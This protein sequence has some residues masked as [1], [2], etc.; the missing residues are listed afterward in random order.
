MIHR[1]RLFFIGV[2]FFC[3]V[4]PVY[5][6]TDFMK[7]K[8]DEP[9]EITANK[10]EAFHEKNLVVFSGNARVIQGN[11]TLKSDRIYLYYK[12]EPGKKQKT[13]MLAAEGGTELDKVEAK[14]N[15]LLIQGDR[16]A[17]GDEALYLR[18]SNR[19]I[20]NGNATLREGKNVIRGDRVIVFLNEDRG[21]VES[22]H[23]QVKAIIYPGET[24]TKH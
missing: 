21:V 24:K 8:A 13:E 5:A 7:G 9:L 12:R 4:F 15:V 10:M 2:L 23:Q 3:W 6:A 11:T 18:E 22:D 14:G 20:L 19:I 17:S 1:I 16:T